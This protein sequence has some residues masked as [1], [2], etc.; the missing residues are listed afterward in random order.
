MVGDFVG[1]DAERDGDDKSDSV[2]WGS[3]ISKKR[4]ED[5]SARY[6]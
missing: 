6:S 2:E 4:E 5:V 3:H 1:E